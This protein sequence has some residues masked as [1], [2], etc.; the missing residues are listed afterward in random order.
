MHPVT[1]VYVLSHVNKATL[2]ER[3]C[4]FSTLLIYIQHLHP[5]N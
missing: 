1:Q 4:T 2:V 3:C 5:R